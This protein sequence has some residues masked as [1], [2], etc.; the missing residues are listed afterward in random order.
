MRRQIDAGA[1]G[2][3]AAT[4]LHAPDPVDAVRLSAE[5]FGAGAEPSPNGTVDRRLLAEQSRSRRKAYLGAG[6]RDWGLAPYAPSDELGVIRDAFRTLVSNVI[7]HRLTRRRLHRALQSVT[8]PVRISLGSGTEPQPGWVGIDRRTARGVY[9]NDLR[10]PLSLPATTVDA[11][12]AEHIVEHLAFDDIEPLLKECRR[13]L[14]PN[15]IV[16][17]VC[18]DA[19]LIGELLLEIESDRVTR[20]LAFEADLNRWADDDLFRIRVANRLSHQWGDHASLLTSGALIALLRRTGFVDI[21]ECAADST[22]YFDDVPGTHLHRFP[23]SAFEAT[24]VEARAP[25]GAAPRTL[26]AARLGAQS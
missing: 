24:A 15:G 16:R 20:Q 11:I 7:G 12:L 4:P 19:K 1:T 3:I 2:V 22:I 8:S 18:P 26:R 21:R 6:V 23:Q 17:I 13:V 5:D 14:K 10:M 25:S 9:A